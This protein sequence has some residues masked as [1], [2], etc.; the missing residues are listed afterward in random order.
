MENGD[1]DTSME[2]EPRR[3]R[4]RRPALR[5]EGDGGKRKGKLGGIRTMPSILGNEICDKFAATG[6]HANMITYLTQVL[7][8]PM[9][10]ASNILTNF[11]GITGFTPLID[12]LIADSFAGRFWTII[13]ASLVY[14][15]GMIGITI[16]ATLPSLRPPACPSQSN[17]QE[18]SPHQ[19]RFLYT[20]LLLTSIGT[21]GIRP[22]V[23]TF[24]A[25]QFD[26]TKS[27][28]AGAGPR[29]WSFFNWYYFCM[30]TATLGALTVVVYVQDNVKLG[31]SPLTRLAQ[32]VVAAVR[33]RK[34]VAPEDPELLYQ[35][36]ELDALISVNGRLLH[37]D[38][39][40]CLDKAAIATENDFNEPP[41]AQKPKLWQLTTVHRVEELKSILR[42]FPI[43]ISGILLV[44]GSSHLNSFVILQ[45]FSMERH[46]SSSSFQIPPASLSIFS[47][48]T[49]MAGLVLYERLFVPFA[50]RFITNN[51]PAGVTCLQRM[52]I[53]AVINVVATVVSAFVEM[54]RKHVAVQHG[55]LDNPKAVVPMSVFWLVP[56]YVLHGAA[57][58]FG[59]VGHIEF[60]Y[61]QSPESMRTTSSA[62]YSLTLSLGNYVG[63]GLVSV[64]HRYTG[65]LPD[66]NLNRGKLDCYYLLVSGIQVVNFVYFLVVAWLY[67]YKPVEEV[68]DGD[69]GGD[70]NG[71]G[72]NGEVEL[73][74]RKETV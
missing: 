19:L 21:G 43:W 6:F 65:W 58:V 61:D 73:S 49:M 56:Q 46:L 57:E 60:L 36:R 34:V 41:P 32:V 50:R 63:T 4:Q 72:E 7:N 55:L 10:K 37:T 31:G 14:E 74:Q 40:K 67:T 69:E 11:G 16:S 5:H 18:A 48:V 1:H 33:K 70:V 54:R 22:C 26:L 44:A 24:A 47:V 20:S 59:A 52:G 17:C 38:Q 30:G 68:K 13:V 15:L 28:A 39:F 29:R 27:S 3:R 53:G 25:D 66:R 35:N 2:E 9:V 71:G 12:A 45:A 8:L 51:N 64:V 23:M 62:L 42:V